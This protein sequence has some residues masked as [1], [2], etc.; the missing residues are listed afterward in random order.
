MRSD[1]GK[2]LSTI[3]RPTLCCIRQCDYLPSL[4][5]RGASVRFLN[6]GISGGGRVSLGRPPRS[7]TLPMR[8]LLTLH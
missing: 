7:G 6:P 3:S 4:F 1:L 2:S 5:S 8:T